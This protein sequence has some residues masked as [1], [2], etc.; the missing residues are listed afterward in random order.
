MEHHA[1]HIVPAAE[2]GRRVETLQQRMRQDGPGLLWVDHLADRL[3]LSG[4]AQDGVVLLPAEGDPRYFVRKSRSRA[5]L[6]S[7]FEVRP[8]PGRRGLVEEVTRL[9]NDRGGERRLGLALDASR[10][11]AFVLLQKGVEGLRIE[12]CFRVF[13]MPYHRFLSASVPA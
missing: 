9:L 7:P 8:W 3:W 6:E 13:E 12:E 5:A 1:P 11:A 10:A 2:V 4:S